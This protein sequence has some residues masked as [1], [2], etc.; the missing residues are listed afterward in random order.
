KGFTLIELVMIIVIIGIL[1]AVAIPRYID[2]QA[3]AQ[4]ANNIAY[5]GALRSAI[6]MRFGEQ[7]LRPGSTP[8]VIGS[9]AIEAPATAANIQALVATAIPS[10]LVAT[11][12]ACGT[13]LWTGLQPSV[14]GAAPASG[15]WTLTCGATA[16]DPI[17]ISGP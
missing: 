17:S 10:T 12:G 6:A 15:T 1:A 9:T 2:L 7:L 4:A 11:A 3:D 8:D 16:N 14:G 13:G 5:V